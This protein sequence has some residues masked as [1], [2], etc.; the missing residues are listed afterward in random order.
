M[1][2]RLHRGLRLSQRNTGT[3]TA[4]HL[5]PEVVVADVLLVGI[6]AC[7]RIEGGGSTQRN[8]RVDRSFRI[9][10]EEFTRCNANHDEWM[11]VDLNLRSDGCGSITKVALRKGV[12]QNHGVGAQV[13]VGLVE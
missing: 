10:T 4:H 5:S 6:L 8:V 2:H 3:Q 1:E 12:A 9:D 13:V 7:K 11:V